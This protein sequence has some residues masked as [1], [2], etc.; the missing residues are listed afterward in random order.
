MKP[1]TF[2]GST[3]WIGYRSHFDMC[4]ELNSWTSQQKGLYLGVSLRGLA[5]G[6]LGNL[7]AK[8]QKDFEVLSKA[9][10][11][12]FSPESQTE[13]YRAQLKER[14]WKHGENLAEFDQRILRL[15]RYLPIL[16][17]SQILLMFWLWDFSWTLYQ[18]LK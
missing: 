7:P 8:D 14:E 15:R 13:L 1:A 4:A 10:G 5:Q 2:D 16:E 9:L 11:E 6:V 18:M 17:Q 3:S 12:R